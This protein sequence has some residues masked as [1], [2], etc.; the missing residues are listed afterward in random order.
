MKTT[1]KQQNDQP[2]GIVI[3]RS[4]VLLV[5]CGIV[6]FLVLGARLFNLQVRQHGAYEAKAIDQQTRE[7]VV[8]A[9]RGTI[10]DRNGKDLAVSATSE[11]VYI[12]PS[13]RSQLN[14]SASEIADALSALLGVDRESVLQKYE[15]TS[16]SGLP[17]K[18]K[19]DDAEAQAVRSFIVE[20]KLRSVYLAPD[21]K[22]HYPQSTLAS[23]VIG[24]VGVENKGLEGIEARYDDYLTGVDGR[25]V[26]LKNMTG[27]DMLFT[28]YENYFAAQDGG[29]ITLTI[30]STIQYYAEKGIAQGV[31]DFNVQN[32]AVAIVM[33]PKNAEILAMATLGTF[34]LNAP[35]DVS[36][37][38]MALLDGL[39][40]E[41]RSTQ[42]ANARTAQW[43][44]KAISD[45]YEPGSV[46]K[47]ITLAIALEEGLIDEHSTFNCNGSLHGILGRDPKNPYHC[48]KTAGHGMQTLSEAVQN[49]CN[50]AFVNIGMM[51]GKERFYR[52]VEAFG[53]RS[54][55]GLDLP[56]EASSIWWSDSVFF[57]PTS[58]TELA[59]ASFGQTFNITPIQLVTAISASVNGGYMYT[60]HIVKTIRDPNGNIVMNA[61]NTPVRQVISEKT[62]AIVREILE[63]VVSVGT[64]ANAKVAGYRVGG[65]TGTSTDTVHQAAT[66]KKEY[67]VSFCGV[68]PMDDPQVVVLVLLDNP[69]A[70]PSIYVSGGGMAAPIVG[71]I[72]SDILPYLG[73]APQYSEEEAKQLNVTVP[74]LTAMSTDNAR[75]TLEKAGLAVKTVGEGDTVTGQMPSAN[76]LVA[77]GTKI[78]IYLGAD[79]PDLDATVTVPSLLNKGYYEAKNALE[80]AGLF[81]RSTG[82]PATTTGAG[83]AVQSIPAGTEVA[84]GTVIEV[85]LVDKSIQ[86]Q[87]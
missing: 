69:N 54:R 61:D 20:N 38:I 68:A 83:V 52:Y 13:L 65:K 46:F 86:G 9:A 79:M 72:L 33:N 3:R 24:F 62:S 22:R 70:D 47:A 77:P 40:P 21:T 27:T 17:I 66:E 48:W 41:E 25:I 85:T 84:Y 57:D 7:A 35:F 19:L 53:L 71:S 75:T 32:G 73:I 1:V 34:D 80:N 78:I 55:T 87:Y 8:R 58:A 63:N 37:D 30:D 14:E 18:L 11:S 6:S 43:R 50:V 51:I 29:D 15:N 42:L 4:F 36:E 16:V 45:T 82:V 67:I 31:E 60:P 56:G 28:D 74:K 49:S 5:V 2:T 64:G 44:N 81:V 12:D 39:P 10:Y 23:S 26:R 59:S 76:A